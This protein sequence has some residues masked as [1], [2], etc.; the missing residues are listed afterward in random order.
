MTVCWT[1]LF[2]FLLCNIKTWSAAHR[3]L[4]QRLAPEKGQARDLCVH[5]VTLA[6]RQHLVCR[7]L[8]VPAPLAQSRHQQRDT[9]ATSIAQV[10]AGWAELTN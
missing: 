9:D 10:Q 5:L 1:A 4:V 2:A 6:G 8:K 7:L 3:Q